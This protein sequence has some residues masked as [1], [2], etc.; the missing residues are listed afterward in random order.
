[1]V[2]RAFRAMSIS[3]PE[4][5]FLMQLADADAERTRLEG[6]IVAVERDIE[7][8]AQMLSNE[9]FVAR[10][11]AAVVEGHRER[12][13]VATERRERLRERLNDLA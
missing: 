10:A 4:R 8:A 9:Q 2:S 1:M 6:E 13:A 5:H 11:P 12:L 7:R 3:S